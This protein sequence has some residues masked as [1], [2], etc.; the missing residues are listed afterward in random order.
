[1]LL[2]KE[3]L[4]INAVKVNLDYVVYKIGFRPDFFYIFSIIA[5]VLTYSFS[6]EIV[7]C[8]W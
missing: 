7:I 1:M 4:N 2:T 3:S 5:N 8:I 6:L